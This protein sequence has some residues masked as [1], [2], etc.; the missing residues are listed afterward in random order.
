MKPLID[1]QHIN[2]RIATGHVFQKQKTILHDISFQ[3]MQGSSTAYLGT[4]GAGKTSTFRILCGL[5]KANSGHVFFDGEMMSNGLPPKR[6]GFMPEQPYFY[7][8]LTPKELLTG[9][10][11]LSGLRNNDLNKDIGVWAERLG[12]TKVLNQRLSTCSKGQVQRV[13]LAQA[14]IHQPDF[15]L[16][17]EPLSGLDPIGRACVR[18]VL[19][20]EIKRGAT[21]LFSS[22]ILSDAEA[23]C[24]QVIILKEGRT[25]FSGGIKSLLSS[26]DEWLL[27]AT[28]KGI[29]PTFLNTQVSLFIDGSYHFRGVSIAA[30][31][32]V[33]QKILADANASLIS[34]EPKQ[35]TL[36]HAFVDLLRSDAKNVGESNSEE[37]HYAADS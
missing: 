24:D 7:K 21:L 4:N 23:I 2:L 26:E 9:L 32:E 37:G 20:A 28:W 3:V 10:G 17:D 5:V 6:F 12:F 29:P 31:N 14:L 22:H 19:H 35:R 15:I 30:R 25:V 34:V 33:I 8:N 11:R 16:L 18:D 36:E 27:K 1:V 13:G